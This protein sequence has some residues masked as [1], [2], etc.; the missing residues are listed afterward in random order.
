MNRAQLACAAAAL[1]CGAAAQAEVTL[2]GKVDLGVVHESGGSAG[3][4]TKLSSGAMAP[5]RL[6]VKADFDLGDGLKA[7]AQL[8]TGVCAD[9]RNNDAPYCTGGNFM[10]RRATLALAGAFGEVSAGRQFVP[11]Y[12]NIDNFDPFGTGT[13]GQATNLFD[14]AG[15][16]ANNSIVYTTPSFGGFSASVLYA[17]GEVNGSSSAGRKLGGSAGYADGPLAVGAA[18]QEDRASDD[19]TTTK[20]GNIGAS[21]DFKVAT[22]NALYQR[23]TGKKS[24]YL[25]GTT[26][27][28][29]GGTVMASYIRLT[30]GSAAKQDASQIGVGYTRPIAKQLKWYAAYAHIS[31]KNGAGYTVGNATDSGSGDSAFNLGLVLSF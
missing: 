27:P 15:L 23:T 1:V 10:G 31:N 16:R 21:Y 9:S 22:L 5:S 2:Y 29:A 3:A 7:K 17:F 30:D 6:G 12:L 28:A 11:A 25:I 14:D 18:Y 19:S 8:E 13:A 4:V 20:H 26:V 24:R